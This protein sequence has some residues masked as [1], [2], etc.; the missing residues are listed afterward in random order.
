[1]N[2]GDFAL[3]SSLL[4]PAVDGRLNTDV[5]KAELSV[6]FTN[7]SIRESGSLTSPGQ[8][9]RAY[10]DGSAEVSRPEWVSMG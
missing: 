7:C 6:P 8:Y 5:M 1:M 3:T 2:V 9:S 10:P 4:P